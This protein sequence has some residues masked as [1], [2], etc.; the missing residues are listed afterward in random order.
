MKELLLH[1][2]LWEAYV[3]KI[4]GV[5]SVI[6]PRGTIY[7]FP[8]KKG[9]PLIPYE[10]KEGY[11][12]LPNWV[13]ECFEAD[14]QELVIF[15][16]PM[17]VKCKDQ[18]QFIDIY[19]LLFWASLGRGTYLKR[20][21]DW[22]TNAQVLVKK[23]PSFVGKIPE[24]AK[25]IFKKF[26][27]TLAELEQELALEKDIVFSCLYPLHLMGFV[28]VMPQ[29]YRVKVSKGVLQSIKD[30]LLRRGREALSTV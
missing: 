22:K 28:E 30:A 17:A 20:Y 4:N 23:R 21:L 5:I 10:L 24:Y 9:Y 18:K 25:S 1:Q 8:F 14:P 19:S 13:Y 12:V 26:K 7:E 27:W 29:R 11:V 2:R 6:L 16:M 3:K 15:V